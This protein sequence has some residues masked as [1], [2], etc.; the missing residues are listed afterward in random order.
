MQ[1]VRAA[2]PPA[3]HSPSRVALA[4]PR[5]LAP[6]S[7][8]AKSQ[9]RRYATDAEQHFKEGNPAAAANS[10]RLAFS[11]SPSDLG[12]K[13]RLEDAE[14]QSDAKQAD[15]HLA[16]AR[17]HENNSAFDLAARFYGKAARG[18]SSGPLY[19]RAAQCLLRYLDAKVDPS[20]RN[21]VLRDAGELAKKAT[22][23]SPDDANAHLLLGEIYSRAGM[24]TSAITQLE[25]AASLKPQ[26]SAIQTGLT[27]LRGEKT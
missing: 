21:Q 2:I 25:K 26:D 15:A 16:S 19:V 5:S 10:L 7:L 22:Q 20:Q 4:T 24:P 14:V 13:Q 27:R 11:L 12:L 17:Q 6:E 1:E 3:T 18:K 8:M 9:A 23:L